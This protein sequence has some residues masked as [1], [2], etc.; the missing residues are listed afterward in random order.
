MFNSMK[1]KVLY[2]TKFIDDDYSAN[3]TSN[4]DRGFFWHLYLQNLVNDVGTLNCDTSISITYYCE[5]FR[6]EFIQRS[7]GD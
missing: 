1:T 2:G 4:P 6:R 5:L 7:I 3:A